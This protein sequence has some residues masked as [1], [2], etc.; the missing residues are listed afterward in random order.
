[1][2]ELFNKNKSQSVDLSTLKRLLKPMQIWN[3]ISKYLFVC[4]HF[5]FF[6]RKI[7]TYLVIYFNWILVDYDVNKLKLGQNLKKKH[8]F[9]KHFLKIILYAGLKHYFTVVG[10]LRLC[11]SNWCARAHAR[12]N[13]Y[14]CLWC[15]DAFFL[16]N[17]TITLNC[18]LSCE[19]LLLNQ[20][21][22]KKAMK[23]YRIYMYI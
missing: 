14:T 19:C 16:F 20:S 5:C 9:V 8:L 3:M 13:P 21:I 2:Q 10:N 17:K 12:G 6:K 1:M 4:F 7:K 23:K 22:E 15:K 11:M 18:V